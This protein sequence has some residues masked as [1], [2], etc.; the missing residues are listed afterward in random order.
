MRGKSTLP[1]PH[2]CISLHPVP[3]HLVTPVTSRVSL[4]TTTRTA[5]RLTVV[6]RSRV[7]RRRR[8]RATSPRC[9]SAPGTQPT[10]SSRPGQCVCAC[11]CACVCVFKGLG[12]LV[13]PVPGNST[14]V[15]VRVCVSRGPIHELCV[16]V[17]VRACVRTCNSSVGR[18]REHV[19]NHNE[20]TCTTCLIDQS[21]ILRM[22]SVTSVFSRPEVSFTPNCIEFSTSLVAGPGTRRRGSGTWMTTATAPTSWCCVTASRREAPRCLA[23]RT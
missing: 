11:A 22:R 6:W 2:Q 13:L 9:S 4:Q 18:G 15:C 16:C 14:S 7:T 23:T 1:D 20:Y 10:T 3:G 8:S 21:A 5:W 12:S 19:K 17:C